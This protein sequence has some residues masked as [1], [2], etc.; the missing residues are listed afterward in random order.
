M[1]NDFHRLIAYDKN[2]E[3]PAFI[4]PNPVE[5]WVTSPHSSLVSAMTSAISTGGLNSEHRVAY[6]LYAGSF[7]LP[8]EPRFALLM[9]ALE[10][11]MSAE[12]RSDHAQL[13]IDRWK[14]EVDTSG[15]TPEEATSLKNAMAFL[16]KESINQTEAGGELEGEAGVVGQQPVV[17]GR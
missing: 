13:L 2:G 1:I 16:R 15:L 10:A 6:G 7:G 12:P 8:P 5:A 11:M 4:I 14:G 9:A 3:K 17:V